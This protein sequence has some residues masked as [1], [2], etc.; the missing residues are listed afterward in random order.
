M[1][2]RHIAQ[3]QRFIDHG[4]CNLNPIGAISSYLQ[5]P[6]L[7][8]RVDYISPNIGVQ[9]RPFSAASFLAGDLHDCS[10]PFFNRCCASACGT[11]ASTRHRLDPVAKC[12]RAGE[13]SKGQCR[14]TGSTAESAE[15]GCAV[16][17]HA[18]HDPWRK[19]RR[20]ITYCRRNLPLR[21]DRR[22]PDRPSRR[23]R[24]S[25]RECSLAHL[26][27]DRCGDSGVMRHAGLGEEMDNGRNRLSRGD[28]L[29]KN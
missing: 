6:P 25:G 15:P 5:Q 22:L 13:I 27:A 11:A 12:Q 4:R 26:R 29:V 3:S 2:R 23:R 16:S 20:A 18:G 28:R 9:Q 10:V 21:R 7:C 19:R 1:P 24:S 17:A 8:S 14:R